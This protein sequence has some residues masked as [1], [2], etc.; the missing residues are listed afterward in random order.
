MSKKFTKIQIYQNLCP[1]NKYLGKTVK[2]QCI[3][4]SQ[5]RH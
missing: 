4:I 5:T 1:G 2:Q 3:D